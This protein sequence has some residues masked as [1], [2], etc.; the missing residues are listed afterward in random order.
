[1]AVGSAL[2]A[3]VGLLLPGELACSST[4]PKVSLGPLQGISIPASELTATRG[5]GTE[6]GNL[7]KYAAVVRSAE[8]TSANGSDAGSNPAL[9]KGLY[10]CFTDAVFSN[11]PY[12]DDGTAPYTIEVRAFDV[13]EYDAQ[14]SA[15]DDLMAAS[16]AADLAKFRA[17]AGARFTCNARLRLHV[18]TTATCRRDAPGAAPGVVTDGGISADAA[19]DA[20]AEAGDASD[21]ASATDAT[22]D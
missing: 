7:F 15:L 2:L 6:S 21:A 17:L 18:L 3:L 13:S 11:L 16:G 12:G 10:D 1:M 20:R 4:S 5:C 9:A 8:A 22:G 14:K 19:A